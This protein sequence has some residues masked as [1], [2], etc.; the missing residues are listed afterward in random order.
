MK[1]L[2]IRFVTH[3]DRRT[4]MQYVSWG[5]TKQSATTALGL[6]LINEPEIQ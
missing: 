3:Y 5:R 4:G 2:P 1:W 6:F